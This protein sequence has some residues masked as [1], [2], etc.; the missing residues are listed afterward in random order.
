M[1]EAITLFCTVLATVIAVSTYRKQI[2]V[3]VNEINQILLEK[4]EFGRRLNLDLITKL[5]TYAINNNSFNDIFMQGLTYQQCIKLLHEVR[6]KV[7]NDY[8]E[9]T[10]KLAIKTPKTNSRRIAEMLSNIE[11]QITHHSEVNTHFNLY[12]DP[13]RFLS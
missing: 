12:V 6:D 2:L 11:I 3:P 5:E 10:I 13:N 4:F 7:F 1:I 8:N 9:E